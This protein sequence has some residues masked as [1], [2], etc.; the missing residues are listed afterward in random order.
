MK[1]D[2]PSQIVFQPFLNNPRLSKSN[3]LATIKEAINNKYELIENSVSI[4]R[5]LLLVKR[6]G[7]SVERGSIYFI[8]HCKNTVWWFTLLKII[9]SKYVSGI[10]ENYKQEMLAYKW[11]DNSIHRVNFTMPISLFLLLC[12]DVLGGLRL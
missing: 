11:G 6:I 8:L 1:W 10:E 3:L 9:I 4:I 2:I 5:Q 7:L 12:L